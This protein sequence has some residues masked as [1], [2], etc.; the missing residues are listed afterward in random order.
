MTKH[1]ANENATPAGRDTR[2]AATKDGAPVRRAGHLADG[3]EPG[4]RFVG[5]PR[6]Q[7]PKLFGPPYS[8]DFW[9]CSVN[10]IND[11]ERNVVIGR[12]RGGC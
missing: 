8:R 1:A 12:T 7:V 3:A 2:A 9:R 5:R 6:V 11:R 4:D 10:R